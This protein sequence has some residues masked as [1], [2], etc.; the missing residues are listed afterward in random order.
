MVRLNEHEPV[1]FV[2][3]SGGGRA[4][5]DLDY[6]ELPSLGVLSTEYVDGAIERTARMA[7]S[8]YCKIR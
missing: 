3:A 1:F 4:K 8:S 5:K 2:K 7:V 6:V